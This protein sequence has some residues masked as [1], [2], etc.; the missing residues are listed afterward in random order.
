[1]S[2]RGLGAILFG[3]LLT[4]VGL[5]APAS[6]ILPPV[7]G[8]Y[9]FH[10]DGLPDVAAQRLDGLVGVVGLR[11]GAVGLDP[12]ALHR[13]PRLI[14]GSDTPSLLTREEHLVNFAGRAKLTN[15]LWTFQVTQDEGLACPDGSFAPTT[16]TYAFTAPDPNGPPNLT[17]TH[18]SIHG[19]VWGLQPGMTKTPFTLTFTDVL[20]PAVISR[21]P[22]LCNYLAGRP[23]ICA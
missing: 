16:D 21:Y 2:L 13:P 20:N 9:T 18:T 23:S 5:A 6:A 11:P 22:A 19:A 12:D 4:A 8:Y 1:M 10:Q 3:A 7:D 17:G 15:D 14:P